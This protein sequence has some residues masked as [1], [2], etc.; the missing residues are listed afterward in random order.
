MDRAY[1]LQS[2]PPENSLLPALG[3][4]LQFG[5]NL[6]L[7]SLVTVA[8]VLGM[9]QLIDRDYRAPD[10][11][12]TIRVQGVVLPELKRT[13]PRFEPPVKPVDPADPP[14]VPPV[15]TKVHKVLLPTLVAPPPPVDPGVGDNVSYRDPIPVFKPAPRYPR[16]ALQRGIEGYVVVEFTITKT[17]SVR[18]VRAVAGY[19]GAG[20][21]TEMF[22]RSAVAAAARFKYQPQI[23]DGE[24]VERHGVRN[25]ITYE[26]AE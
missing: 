6:A 25:R 10:N 13:P 21:P 14:P 15:E 22:N 3:R 8:L 23:R 11:G 20:N 4:S 24:A 17:G 16:I 26:I 1:L 18:D 19:D 7:A 2:N 12:G 5:R 9:S